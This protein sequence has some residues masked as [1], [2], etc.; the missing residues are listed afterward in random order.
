MIPFFQSIFSGA[1]MSCLNWLKTQSTQL[2]RSGNGRF[3]LF[4]VL[5]EFSG[6]GWYLMTSVDDAVDFLSWFFG[7]CDDS[8]VEETYRRGDDRSAAAATRWLQLA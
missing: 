3:P 4:W 2:L 7:P 8:L 1:D 5:T 6:Y